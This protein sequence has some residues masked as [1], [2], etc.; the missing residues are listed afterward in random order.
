MWSFERFVEESRRATTIPQLKAVFDAALAEDGYQN[1]AMVTAIDSQTLGTIHWFEFPRGYFETYLSEGWERFDPLIGYMLR[2]R[3]PF[4]WD[5]VIAAGNLLPEQVAFMQDIQTL[6]VQSGIVFPLHGP[7]GT[8][9]SISKRDRSRQDSRRIPVL[10]A[11]CTQAWARYGELEAPCAP[12]GDRP[13]LTAREAEI[14]NWIKDGK[15]NSQISDILGVSV[16]TVEYHV[17]N[18]LTKLGAS[19]RISAVVMALRCGLLHL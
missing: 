9:I 2:A 12:A 16:K 19:N 13:V 4:L 15:N 3:G 14:L 17:G 6:G 18:I 1:H 5:E 7:C 10:R 8:H 11:I